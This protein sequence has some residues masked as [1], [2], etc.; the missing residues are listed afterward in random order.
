MTA[1]RGERRE[2]RE[3]GERGREEGDG[4]VT[5]AR[6]RDRSLQSRQETEWER[7]QRSVNRGS[8][9]YPVVGRMIQWSGFNVARDYTK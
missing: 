8:F 7:T 9:P 2:E 5:G 3:G 1:G 4:V 6:T